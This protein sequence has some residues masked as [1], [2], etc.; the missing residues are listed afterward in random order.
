MKRCWIAMLLAATF[1]SFVHARDT[2]VNIPLQ[3]VLDMPEAKEQLDGSVKFILAGNPVPAKAAL[4]ET[5]VSNKKTNA[6]GKTDEFACRW[7][8]LSAL[9]SFQE[10]AKRRG[11]N[12]VVNMVSYYKKNETKSAT[13]L[14]CHAGNIMA[15]LALKGQYAKLP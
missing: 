5:D 3:D 4:L 13:T 7:A 6:V 2:V 15:G 14:E 9:K 12:A 1:S 8:A 10:G 11:A